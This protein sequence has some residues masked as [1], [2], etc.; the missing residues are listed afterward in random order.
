VPT[1]HL[2][3]QRHRALAFAIAACLAIA[4]LHVDAA[5]RNFMWKATSPS[6][7]V[8]YLVGSVHVLTADY[9]PL[10]PA[11]EEAF[12][13]SD[14][15]VEELDM[16]E[17]LGASSQMEM[18]SR[19]MLPAGQTIDKVVS[20]DTMAAVT[21]KFSDLGMPLEPMKQFKPWLMSLILQGF[22][23]QKSGFDADLGLDKHFYD[24]AIG[25]GKQV[26]GLET[27]AFQLS[28]F[29]EMSMDAQDRLLSETI[30]ELDTTKASFT[31]MA[32]A[33]KAGD[34]PAIEQLVL[35]DL[36]DEP[37]MYDR[38]LIQR[39]RMWLPKIEALFSRPKPAFVVV[40][41]AHLVGS[42]GLLQMLQDKGYT[43]EQM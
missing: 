36:K 43:I 35:K 9:Y 10:D 7:R 37:Q 13:F 42:D 24:Q 3:V 21:K 32:D 41:A 27:L 19:G 15:L 11:F 8:V 40:G 5:G 17:M 26:Q 34:V 14:V 20:A 25:S 1:F 38:L 39:N 2:R 6:H 23:W 16:R 12:K 22:E 18:L 31:R 4:C 33:W 30:N 29:D 28:R